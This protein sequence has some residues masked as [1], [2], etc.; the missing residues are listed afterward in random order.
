[1][2]IEQI[3]QLLISERDKLTRAIEAPSAPTKRRGR[4]RTGAYPEYRCASANPVAAAEAQAC[5]DA[6]LKAFPPK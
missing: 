1:M 6:Q 3:V 5:S 4:P 2:A